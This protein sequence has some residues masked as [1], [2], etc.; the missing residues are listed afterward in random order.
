MAIVGVADAQ[1]YDRG[2]NM[3]VTQRDRPDYAALGISAGGFR[4]YPRLQTQTGYTS[5]LYAR[6]TNVESDSYFSFVPNIEAVSN[7]GRHQLEASATLRARRYLDHSSENQ[8]SWTLHTSGRLDVHGQ[9]AITGVAEVQRLYEERSSSQAPDAAA[10]PLPIDL[11]VANVR[12]VHDFNRIRVSSGLYFRKY[13]Y[14]NVPSV[15][16]GVVD[17]SGRDRNLYTGDIKGEYAVSP[18]TAVFVVTSYTKT[19]YDITTP[20][21]HGSKQMQVLGGANFDLTALGRGEIGLG[22]V[23]RKYNDPSVSRTRGFAASANVEYFPTRTTTVTLNLRRTVEDAIDFDGGGFFVTT[24]TLTVDHELRRNILVNASATLEDQKY[25]S[26][27]RRNKTT[28]YEVGGSYLVNRGIG[29]N[30]S[31]AQI[32]R[33]SSGVNRLHDFDE[34]RAALG[35]VLQR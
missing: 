1:T 7:W 12:G 10:K 29:L 24:G 15:S 3:A 17:V 4:I 16:G 32:Q 5:N 21:D 11:Y 30:L 35:V 28:R 26:L 8:N 2:R 6:D 31:L 13:N 20:A 9:D 34:T 33:N 27:D 23:A 18:D 25:Q 19:D 22:Y 14:H